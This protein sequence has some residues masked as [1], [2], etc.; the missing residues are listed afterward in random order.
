MTQP[1]GSLVRVFSQNAESAKLLQAPSNDATQFPKRP[2]ARERHRGD[3]SGEALSTYINVLETRLIDHMRRHAP[4]WHDRE[5]RKILNRWNAPQA[6]HPAP[7]WAAARDT[8]TAARDYAA[9]LVRD[10][11]TA[12]MHRLGD[13]RIARYLGGHQQVDPLHLIFHGKSIQLEATKPRK[14]TKNL[15]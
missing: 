7:G 6:Q 4:R 2:P 8:A 5:T 9:V 14:I 12:R 13:I 1:R 3:F 11:L 10:R 15:K